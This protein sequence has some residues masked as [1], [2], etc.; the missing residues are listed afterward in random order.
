[1]LNVTFAPDIYIFFYCIRNLYFTAIIFI[2]SNHSVSHCALYAGWSQR[3]FFFQVKMFHRWT[4][5]TGRRTLYRFALPIHFKTFHHNS[6]QITLSP[7]PLPSKGTLL[8]YHAINTFPSLCYDIQ[9]H[10][11]KMDKPR[12]DVPK[13]P[14]WTFSW[15]ISGNM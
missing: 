4:S 7:F 15:G 14:N 8:R 11:K 3:H 13:L 2:P 1:M 10:C 6:H 5:W 9:I 12:H